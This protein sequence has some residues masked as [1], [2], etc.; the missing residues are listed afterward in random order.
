MN[1][2]QRPVAKEVGAARFGQRCDARWF[3]PFRQRSALRVPGRLLSPRRPS[4]LNRP[5][6]SRHSSRE[7]ARGER[8]MERALGPIDR[9][10]VSMTSRVPAARTITILAASL[11]AVPMSAA[12]CYAATR[13]HRSGQYSDLDTSTR[14]AEGGV[15]LSNRYGGRREKEARGVRPAPRRWHS[16]VRDHR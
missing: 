9:Q 13:D 10:E 8:R 4:P 6:P 12:D 5:P 14:T 2:A 15:T 11:V 7:R 3:I 1:P 16:V